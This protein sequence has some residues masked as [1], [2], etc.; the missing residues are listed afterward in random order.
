MK[1]SAFVAVLILFALLPISQGLAQQTAASTPEVIRGAAS[2][3][4]LPRQAGSKDAPDV[5]LAGSTVFEPQSD[6]SEVWIVEQGATSRN[7]PARRAR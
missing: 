2:T 4:V 1:A 3:I 7:N 5:S 6:R